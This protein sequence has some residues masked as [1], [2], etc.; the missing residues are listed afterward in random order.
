MSAPLLVGCGSTTVQ[1]ASPDVEQHQIVVLGQ[2]EVTTP[3]DIAQANLGIEILS[4]T[5]GEATQ[6]ANQR[7][8]AIMSALKQLGIAEKDIRTS[9][10]TVNFERQ[11]EPPHPYPTEAPAAP[12]MAPAPTPKLGSATKGAAAGASAAAAA[13]APATPSIVPVAPRG[14]YRVSNTVEITLRDLSKVGPALDAA[15]A[16]GANNIWGVS[17]SI[18]KKD[19]VAAR[20]RDE[21]MKDARSRAEALARLGGVTL[22]ELVSIREDLTGGVASPMPR[23][24]AMSAGYGYAHDSVSISSGE[25]RFGMQIRVVYTLKPR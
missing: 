17:F 2:A 7:M 14:F 3:P 15:M 19:A 13:S 22:G 23:M 25:V 4:A 11:P 10:F 21:A 18:D 9:N 8:A 6:Q 20:A 24:Q 12:V 5:V 1:V 16:A